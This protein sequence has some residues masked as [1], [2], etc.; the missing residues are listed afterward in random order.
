[1]H[2]VH[3]VIAPWLQE[4]QDLMVKAQR[5]DLNHVI[6]CYENASMYTKML[7]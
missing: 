2:T 3:K 1:M 6:N 7:S 4:A 5:H